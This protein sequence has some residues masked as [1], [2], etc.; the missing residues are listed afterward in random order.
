MANL[1]ASKKDSLASKKRRIY[2]VSKRSMI[3]TFIKKVYFFI[4]E[5]NK[6]K[7]L[8][9]FSLM[10]PILDRHVAKGIIH[11]NKASRHKSKLINCIKKII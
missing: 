7:A 5:G 1:K 10:Q 2:N 8:H 11:I 6:K 9:A 3:K 4:K